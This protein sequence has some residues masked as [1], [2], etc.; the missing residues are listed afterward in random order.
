M[1]LILD[2]ESLDKNCDNIQELDELLSYNQHPFDFFRTR[3]QVDCTRYSEIGQM[4]KPLTS[5][6]IS[7]QPTISWIFDYD[8]SISL[9]S[10]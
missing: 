1:K 9:L 7:C 8:L 2:S 10:V 3:S 6:R 5:K 4:E